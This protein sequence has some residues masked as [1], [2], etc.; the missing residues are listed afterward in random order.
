MLLYITTTTPYGFLLIPI[1]VTLNDLS[2]LE[3]PFYHKV[4]F[5]GG[6]PDENMLLLS[7]LTMCD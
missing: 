4:R 2:V 5:S 3:Y 1:R 6:T 7:E